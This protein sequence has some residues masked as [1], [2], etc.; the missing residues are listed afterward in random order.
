MKQKT[1]T[2]RQG[3]TWDQIAYRLWKKEALMGVLMHANPE[4]GDVL[5]F[6]ADY[7]L[8][9]PNIIINDTQSGLPPWMED[10]A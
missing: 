7:T 10:S 5:V 9:V 4:Y 8:I 3:D 1:Y 6:P 2:T